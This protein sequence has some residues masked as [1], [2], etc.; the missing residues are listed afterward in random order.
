MQE[1]I[2]IINQKGGVGKSTTVHAIGAGLQLQGN[3][4]LYVDLD[5]QGNLTHTLNAANE[6]I[7][8]FDV[9]MK[10]AT[11]EQVIKHFEKFDVISANANLSTAD[12]TIIGVGK[13]YRLKEAIMP[14]KDNYDY[15]LIDTPPSLGILT[16]NALTACTSVIIPAQADTY[17]LQGISQL[18]QTI[19]AVKEYCNPSLEIKGIVLTRY[20]PRTVL[21]RDLAEM[22]KET[23]DKMQ[24]QLYCTAIRECIAIK[25]AQAIQKD[26]FS[27]APTCNAAIDYN[28]LIKEII[29]GKV[30]TNG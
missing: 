15:I 18:N 19:Q 30:H 2:S 7:T 14:I 9:L 12:T 5:A 28:K 20:N 8:I 3:K 11:A 10:Q 26:I 21:S 17:S 29:K 4:V 22:T 6:E 27:Y 24:T 25:E 16:I 1:I 23:A 13:E